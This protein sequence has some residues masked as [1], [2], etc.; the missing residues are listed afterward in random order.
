PGQVRPE[1][2]KERSAMLREL[3][4]RKKTEF[5]RG[6][7]GRTLSILVE[8]GGKGTTPNYIPVRLTGGKHAPGEEIEVTITGI[9][10][11]EALAAPIHDAP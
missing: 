10:G 7:I 2:I 4:I 3:G 6:F 1:T 8:T 11:E 9:S 5:Y